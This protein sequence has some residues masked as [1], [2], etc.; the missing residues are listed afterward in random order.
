M[1]GYI[2][3]RRVRLGREHAATGKTRHFVGGKP[4][5]EPSELRIARYPDDPGYYLLYCDE[6]G[7][8]LTDTFHETLES[9]LAQAEWEYQVRADEWETVA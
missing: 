6:A 2:V 8:E 1:T 7:S 9:A 4:L 5:S 3:L